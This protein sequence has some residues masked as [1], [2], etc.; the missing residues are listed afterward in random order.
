MPSGMNQV[1]KPCER[2]GACHDSGTERDA[3]AF[4]QEISYSCAARLSSTCSIH[5][6]GLA[7]LEEGFGSA[8]A[9]VA[10][11][12]A[13]PAARA[14]VIRMR[15]ARA[16]R[17]PATSCSSDLPFIASSPSVQRPPNELSLHKRRSDSEEEDRQ[18]SRCPPRSNTT[19][20][21][22]SLGWTIA[23]VGPREVVPDRSGR[24]PW[25]WIPPLNIGGGEIEVRHTRCE[26]RP[27]G[28]RQTGVSRA[29]DVVAGH[30]VGRISILEP[31]DRP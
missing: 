6:G 21:V 19:V 4:C 31:Q 18:A 30:R 17:P 8:R 13:V 5:P 10:P 7:L 16:V 14:S 27:G 25:T 22:R 2:L 3:G 26:E 23:V 12:C 15:T 29:I 11:T 20:L 24:W 9:I 28:E 1:R